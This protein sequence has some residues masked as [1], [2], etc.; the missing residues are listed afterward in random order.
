MIMIFERN[1]DIDNYTFD[2]R[3]LNENAV[4][5][6]SVVD[7]LNKKQTDENMILS[8]TIKKNNFIDNSL[9]FNSPIVENILQTIE[10]L[11]NFKLT[12]NEVANGI[13][14]HHDCVKKKM[15][16]IL[17]DNFKIGDGIFALSDFE[18]RDLKLSE[19]EKTLIKPYFTT[20]ELF[21]YFGDSNNK[22][23][24]I[25]TSSEFKNP[26]KMK[27]YPNIKNH[28]DKFVKVITSDNKPYGLH[29][30]RNEKF[31]KGKK[32][33]SLRK[34]S[35]SPSFTYTNFDCY[36]S[37]TFYVIKTMRANQIFLIGFLNSSLCAFWLRYKGKMQGNNYQIDKEPLLN[38]PI[39][40][41]TEGLQ[42][43]IINFV[44]QILNIKKVNPQA[45][46][47]ALEQEIDQLVYKLYGLS[48][49]EI[50]IVEDGTK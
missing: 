9:I 48:E 18:L 13:H 19:K 4:D 34:C 27:P 43:P 40:V 20:N 26:A 36:V 41:V 32:I 1:S 8:P 7:L 33:I 28:L 6:A 10:Q 3:K 50:K 35:D 22:Y 47:T 5:F 15:L 44:N 37:A 11:D 25:Y 14:S 49:E 29:R 2:Y 12:E 17:D 46:T 42:K 23:W 45:K 38:I 30:A 24:I 31:F 39:P 16:E 21:R